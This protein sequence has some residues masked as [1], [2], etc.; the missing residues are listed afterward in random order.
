MSDDFE[1]VGPAAKTNA[2]KAKN[3]ASPVIS[4]AK[5]SGTSATPKTLTTPTSAAARPQRARAAVNYVEIHS[6]DDVAPA[7]AATTTGGSKR[8][9][10]SAR[11]VRERSDD[12][13]SDG[14]QRAFFG[15]Q[16]GLSLSLLAGLV[17]VS[18]L[19]DQE[20]QSKRSMHISC[21]QLQ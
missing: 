17:A 5:L 3:A 6:D 1:F 11:H 8:P 7:A 18:T 15:C 9:G 16:P 2:G 21:L 10:S 20:G 13:E 4:K 12:S 14:R 19:Q